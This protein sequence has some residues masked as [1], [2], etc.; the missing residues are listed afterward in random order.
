[1]AD[2]VKFVSQ[3]V[4]EQAAVKGAQADGFNQPAY[5]RLERSG[6]LARFLREPDPLAAILYWLEHV[7]GTKVRSSNVVSA[8]LC[9]A[10]ADIDR[11]INLQLN[12]IL[13]HT[14][15]QQLE[16]SWR[17]VLYLTEQT[18]RHDRGQKVKVKLLSLS[19][20]ELS[21]DI[22]RAIDFDQSDFF[23]LIR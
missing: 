15:F 13:H 21:K 10:I 5:T 17:G 16:A 19:W 3:D 7:A 11:L 2:A 1:M 23:K 18:E 20:P 12:D 14:L 9:R 6:V 22:S 4:F 8:M